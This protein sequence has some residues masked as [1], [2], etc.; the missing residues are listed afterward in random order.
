MVSGLRNLAGPLLACAVGAA[1]SAATDETSSSGPVDAGSLDVVDDG[2]AAS[3]DADDV[4]CERGDASTVA[5]PPAYAGRTS[6]LGDAASAAAAGK[7]LFAA[8]CALCHGAEGR[9]DGPEGPSEP[10]PANLAAGERTDAYIFWRISEGG[11][12]TPFCSA[13]PAFAYLGERARWELVA[14]V[15]SLRPSDDAG[16]SDASAE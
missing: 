9:G 12:T 1:C 14:F 11:R 8:R 15:K 3:T 4:S 5:V 7:T 2:R 13:M 10:R 16:P 6:P